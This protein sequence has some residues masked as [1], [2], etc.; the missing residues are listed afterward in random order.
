MAVLSEVSDAEYTGNDV[1]TA[2]PVPFV[3]LD[4]AHVKVTRTVADVAHVLTLGVEYTLTGAR[5]PSG[6]TLTLVDALPEGATLHVG[7]VVPLTQ[8]AQLRTGGPFSPGVMEDALDLAAMRAQQEERERLVVTERT[9]FLEDATALLEGRADNLEDARDALDARVLGVESRAT[10]VEARATSL[11]GRA[12]TLEARATAVEGRATTVEGRAG[13]LEAR[14]TAVEG[15]ASSLE[16]RT[17]VLEAGGG[18]GGGGSDP[19]LAGRVTTLEGTAANLD[20][21]TTV[22][23]STTLPNT[24][25]AANAAKTAAEAARDAAMATG[26]VYADTAAG[27]AASVEGQYFTVPAATSADSLVLYR[28]VSSAAVEVKRYPSTAGVDALSAGLTDVVAKRD[29][30]LQE[31]DFTNAASYAI[32]NTSIA[33][34]STRYSTSV[35]AGDLVINQTQASVLLIGAL[36]P[37]TAV[38]NKILRVRGVFNSGIG[39]QGSIGIAFNPG[40]ATTLDAS[41]HIC[42]TWRGNNGAIT[43]YRQ[44]GSTVANAALTVSPSFATTNL[45]TYTD[46]DVVEMTAQW[47]DD[48]SVF[49]LRCYK[50]GVKT[51]EFFFSGLGTVYVGALMRG[52]GPVNSTIQELSLSYRIERE[53]AFYINGA[54]GAGGNGTERAPFNN[55][56][57]AI[58]KVDESPGSL[59]LYLKGGIY[60][61]SIQLPATRFRQVEII[62]NAGDETIIRASQAVTAGW[63]KTAGYTNVYER[64]HSFDGSAP[65]SSSGGGILDFT[66]PTALLAYR[67]YMRLAPN[68]ALA[69]LDSTPGACMVNTT[70][71]KMY[72][73]AYGSVDPNGLSLELADRNFAVAILRGADETA[74]FYATVRLRNLVAQYAYSH[75]FAIQR[76]FVEIENCQGEGSAVSNGFGLDD[77]QGRLFSCVGKGN[78]NDGFNALGGVTLGRYPT[79]HFFDCQ[80]IRN[81]VGDGL[82]NH[83][84]VWHVHGGEFSDNGKDGLVP[85]YGSLYAYGV[86]A[87]R[88]ANNGFQL[89]SA[90]VGV[91]NTMR[92]V[93]CEATANLNGVQCN[94]STTGAT[95]LV[96]VEG[97]RVADNT[98][99][100]LYVFNSS[101]VPALATLIARNVRGSGNALG[102]VNTLGV[103]TVINDG[104]FS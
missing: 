23:E 94:R 73:H 9:A 1:A 29:E 84:C 28:E 75:A 18:G 44:D 80:G 11:E 86:V 40:S 66:N 99:K 91:S 46:G 64:D 10:N 95:S 93:N 39:A 72:V 4:V 71:K 88:N 101:G 37:T 81:V 5:S 68:G 33:N 55:L 16:T 2:F 56:T 17:S 57:S 62:G 70:A 78:W 50:A 89:A 13:T 102:A 61:G 60:R 90:P 21:R 58:L 67:I 51:N 104:T 53:R 69:T 47:G 42:I 3:Y 7:R 82:S 41:N 49:V 63:T 12:G 48:P 15:R 22:I 77:V 30:A 54:A 20:A 98:A 92:L 36:M 103:L 43:L 19:L 6:G 34:P 45:V 76:C 8:G 59:R 97:G 31:V 83:N 26:R 32:V 25:A 38:A 87:R 96:E 79:I 74:N 100:G 65:S 85:A 14:A 52:V 27:L 35:V 24:V